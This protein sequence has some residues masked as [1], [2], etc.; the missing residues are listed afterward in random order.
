MAN[1]LANATSPYLLQHAKNP[2][3]WW[4][5]SP[6]AFADARA[7]DVPV[8]LSV[9][10]AACHWC[11]VMAHE[12]FED[13]ATAEAINAAFVPVKVDREERPDVDAVYM[14]AT[15]AMTGQG[16]WPMTVFLT[17]DGHP[18]YAGTYFPQAPMHGL[19]SF[20]QVLDAVA[21]A[22]QDRRDELCSGAADISRRLADGG[23]A[24]LAGRLDL[25]EVAAAVDALAEDYDDRHGGFGGAPKFPPAM[26]VEA[27]LRFADSR[28]DTTA[29]A[30]AVPMALH[31]LVAM[32]EGG[33]HDQLGGGFS[34]YSV[35]AGWVVP[36]F[37][38]ML[39]DNGLL[40]GAYLHGWR[41]T[42]DDRLLP[43]ITGV[44]DWLLTEMQT[45][46]GGFAASLD[47]DSPGPDGRPEEGAFY[48]WT[49]DQ[50]RAAV[51]PATADW[52]LEHCRVTDHGTADHGRS[53]LQLHDLADVASPQ[54]RRAR[55]RLAEVR[56]GRPRPGCD[57]KIVA[58]W[59]GWAIDALA[60]AGALLDRPDWVQAA[61]RA[62]SF[63]WDRHW[64]GGRLRRTSRAGR[65]GSADGSAEDYAAL[66]LAAVRLA[67]VTADPG[68]ADRA[69][70]LLTAL[71]QRFSAPDGGFFDAADDAEALIS[72]PKDPTDNA[73]PSGLSCAVH[74]FG[75]LAAYTGDP[76]LLQRAERA[77]RSA[78]R[79]VTAA[80]RFAGWLLADWV[81]RVTGAAVEVAIVGPAEDRRTQE[82]AGVA[83]RTAPAGSVLVIGAPDQPGVPLLADR[84]LVDGR[85]TAYVCR[86]FVCR[87][88][89][90]EAG[91]LAAELT[92]GPR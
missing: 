34:R 3:D 88:P 45:P 32:A 52:V 53:T 13:P 31:T 18:I 59:N 50:I 92:G 79:L 51:D 26:V 15:Q 63:V 55:P 58:A 68:W 1:R 89:L 47:A 80:P 84:I 60:E 4:E 86:R 85:P 75:R 61:V 10:Y 71:D 11:H 40:L 23:T 9:G 43:V 37:E 87:M 39:Y 22:W 77:A 7:R 14:Q 46:E 42:G 48:L 78:A 38:K 20:G 49:P 27:L 54:W 57:D 69:R 66:G 33:I 65:V 74:A 90:T 72:R 67:E 29:G 64:I 16:G 82:L 30:D 76:G 44:A 24:D 56:A 12:S 36:H 28:P 19:P 35:D 17:P 25:A 81:T 6:E 2:V 91:D 70:T 21:E 41:S 5:W 8:L 62:A 83:R 73:T